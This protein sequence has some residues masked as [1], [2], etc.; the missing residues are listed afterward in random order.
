[1]PDVALNVER[2]YPEGVP[3]GEYVFAADTVPPRFATVGVSDDRV[4]VTGPLTQEQLDSWRQF[5]CGLPTT[6]VVGS[7]SAGDSA[8]QSDSS[9][10]PG[11]KRPFI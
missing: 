7:G 8:D 4:W 3:E 9:R 2:M 5:I 6:A 11:I 10:L 1:M